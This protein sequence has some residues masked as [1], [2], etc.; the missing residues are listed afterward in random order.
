[1]LDLTSDIKVALFFAMCDYESETKSYKA[2]SDEKI[3]IGYVYA[4]LTYD[5]HAS[6]NNS[7]GLFSHRVKVIGMQPFKRPG[8]QKGFAYH[9]EDHDNFYGYLY[10]FNYTKEDSLEIYNYFDK[11]KALWCKDKIADY[12]EMIKQSKEFSYN[13]VRATSLLERFNSFSTTKRVSQLK[14]NG[15]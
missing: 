7:Y 15:D 4:T 12:T 13:A 11:G 3:Y 2:K 14:K 9:M 8:L 5:T 6:K 1:M 10:S